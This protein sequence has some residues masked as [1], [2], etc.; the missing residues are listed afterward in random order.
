[1]VEVIMPKMGDGMEE[2]T[3][4][5]WLKA[6]GEEVKADEPIAN[7]QTDKAVV[8]ITA[9]SAGVLSGI[10]VKPDQTVPIGTRLAAVVKV[11][12]ALPTGWGNG[13]AP[14]PAPVAQ[15]S[16]SVPAPATSVVVAE[17][18]VKA[19][20]L[21][22]K[23]AASLGVDIAS[24]P[25][26]GPG[27]RI[28][29]RDVRGFTPTAAPTNGEA[30]EVSRLRKIIG[31]RTQAAKRDAPHFY[32]TVEVDVEELLAL[33]EQ[34][35]EAAPDTKISINDFVMKACTVALTQMPEANSNLTAEGWVV[36]D[37][38]NIGMA[39]ATDDGL[40]VPVVR[41]CEAKTLRQ[42]SAEAKELARRTR[43]GKASLDDL[44][45]STFSVSNMGMLNVENF[46]AILNTPNVAIVAV[47]SVRRQPVVTEDGRIEARSRMNVSGSF[48]HRIIDGAIGARFMNIL[49]DCL[50]SP[51][52]LLS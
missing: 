14:A 23:I 20:P 37:A 22:K 35:N 29:E 6:E 8:E 47:S 49:R 36:S 40:L 30:R 31:E 52:T 46:I 25:G 2:G 43:E 34:M 21:A 15:A 48:D 27:G 7:I 9:P 16:V 32:V 41:N 18:R 28:V 39:V 13:A 45:G 38:V 5:E 17:G 33:R 4:I 24:V 3:L 11:G 19:S 12:E 51:I 10:L 1:M 44:T 26:T 50:Q 42:I